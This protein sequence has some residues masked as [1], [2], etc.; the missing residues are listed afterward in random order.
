M[1]ITF[2]GIA[3][4]QAADRVAD[5]MREEGFTNVIIDMG[6]IAALGER[7]SVR[8]AK[9]GPKTCSRSSKGISSALRITQGR[10]DQ[11]E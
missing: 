10:S 2:N 8:A 4:G 6:E 7:P 3:Q 9:P 11:E 1:Q 5:L